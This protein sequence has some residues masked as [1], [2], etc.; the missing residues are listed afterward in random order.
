MKQTLLLLFTFSAIT[1]YTFGQSS[2]TLKTKVLKEAEIGVCAIQTQILSKEFY[3]INWNIKYFPNKRIGTG[4][5]ITFSQKK[6]S[7]TFTYSIKKPIIDYYE[8]GWTNQYNFLKTKRVQIDI[9]LINAL[10]MSRLGDNAFKERYHKYMAKEVA[11]NYF[12]TLAPGAGFAF[13]LISTN[14]GA[15][16]WLTAETNYRFVFGSSKYA[17]TKQFSGYLFGIGISIRRFTDD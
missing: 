17:I 8:I 7:D 14:D 1:G 11:T 9:S 4:A 15:G 10:S 16:I 5:Y 6:I 2:D 13:K 3:G 12:Y